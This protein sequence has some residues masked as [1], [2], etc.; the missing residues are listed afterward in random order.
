[1]I[2]LIDIAIFIAIT[3]ILYSYLL[4]P[5]LLIVFCKFI[6]IPKFEKIH[7]EYVP[8]VDFLITAYN[9]EDSIEKK[10]KNTLEINYPENFFNI[11]VVSDG[12]IDNTNCIVSKFSKNNVKLLKCERLGKSG[13]INYATQYLKSDII[14]FSDANT[15]YSSNAVSEIVSHF[16][17]NDVGCVSGRLIYRNPHA[18]VSG[19]GE[20]LYWKY[21]NLLKILESQLGYIAGANGA[22]YAIRRELFEPFPPGTIN[23]DFTLSMRIIEKGYKSLYEPNALV[24]EDVAPSIISEFKRHIRDGAGHYVAILH[25][26]GL[27][28]P[29]HGVRSFI[30]W[31]HRV[32]RW[33]V[34]FLMVF[35]F[36][37]SASLSNFFY[38]KIFFLLQCIFY[39]LAIVGSFYSKAKRVPFFFFAPYYFCN[40]NL[41][42]LF[43]F[44]KAALGLQGAK[45][46][47]DKR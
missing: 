31:S 17:D 15:E 10:I 13:A 22:I 35:I 27:L 44:I 42:L 19:V 18:T 25:L 3:I 12:S 43:G 7:N 36:F 28:N 47:P 34:P 20:G 30:F 14:F 45:W 40:L 21:E 33:V 26:R 39:S 8:S 41:A 29:C 37:A 23:D 6:S 5:I 16:F 1:M 24:Y 4:Y 2:T 38:Y 46:T 9:E 32:L 11:W